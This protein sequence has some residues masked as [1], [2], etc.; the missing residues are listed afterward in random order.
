MIATVLART[1]TD[2][3]FTGYVL[4]GSITMEDVGRALITEVVRD[5]AKVVL[6]ALLD[7]RYGEDEDE[8]QESRRRVDRAYTWNLHFTSAHE[9]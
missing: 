2:N 6:V 3:V 8:S 7:G 9:Q 1:Q 5:V 4:A